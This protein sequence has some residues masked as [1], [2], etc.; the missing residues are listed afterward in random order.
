M[1]DTDII[2]SKWTQTEADQTA[3]NLQSSMDV[4]EGSINATCGAIV[5][6][7]TYWYLMDFRWDSGKWRYCTIAKRTFL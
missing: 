1:D 4:W 6:D 5:L 3:H 7:K 2:E